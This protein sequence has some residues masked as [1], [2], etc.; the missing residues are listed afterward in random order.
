MS[1][2]LIDYYIKRYANKTIIER[3]W[4]LYK[5][6]AILELIHHDD[7]KTVEVVVEGEKDI[8]TVIISDYKNM[9]IEAVCDCPYNF[10][11]IC[12]HSVA[13]LYKLIAAIDKTKVISPVVQP[14][15]SK[16]KTTTPLWI[17]HFDR[18]SLSNLSKYYKQGY[19]YYSRRTIDRIQITDEGLSFIISDFYKQNYEYITRI[20][21]SNDQYYSYC[22][23]GEEVLVTCEHE[24]IVIETLINAGKRVLP[25]FENA[26]LEE[27]MNQVCKDN[28]LPDTYANSR[29]LQINLDKNFMPLV[30]FK[31]ELKGLV[32]QNTGF[33]SGNFY[34][35]FEKYVKLN[36]NKVRNIFDTEEYE[37][38]GVGFVFAFIPGEF[39]VG[40][41][42]T[43]IFGKL[44]AAGNKIISN[45][46]E[47]TVSDLFDINV[48]QNEREAIILSEQIAGVLKMI[49][50]EKEYDDN[51]YYL[52]K[53]LGY[54]KNLFLLLLGNPLIYRLKD[55]YNAIRKS[56]LH[57]VSIAPEP[58][59]L[60]AK[61]VSE[62]MFIALVPQYK[63]GETLIDLDDKSIV[64]HSALIWEFQGVLHLLRSV[65]VLDA[66]TFVISVGVMKT[67]N[68]KAGEFITNIVIP[69][70][71]RFKLDIDGLDNFE[72]DEIFLKPLKKQVFLS[73]HKNLIL[74]TPLVVYN[75]KKEA[76]AMTAGNFIEQV[77]GKIIIYKR[78]EDFEEEFL[79]FLRSLH[80]DF[81]YQ[82][83]ESAMGLPVA[84]MLKNN[85]F[86][87]AFDAMKEKNIEVHG[88]Q[89]LKSFKYSPYRATINTGISSGQDWFDVNLEVSFGDHKIPLLQLRKHILNKEKFIKLGDGTVGMM[90]G[91]W[92]DKLE[93]YFRIG[94][95]KKDKLQVS[96][97]RFSLVDELFDNIDDTDILQE[98]AEKK[99]RLEGFTE[100]SKVR[101]PSAIK[102]TLRDYQKEGL[103]WLNFLS[104]MS[105]GG[106]LAD[107]M[108]LGKTLQILAFLA[109][110]KNKNPKTSLV[111]VPTTLIFN[112][113]NEIKKFYPTLNVMFYY[114]LNRE[115][116]ENVFKKFN[117]VI[118]TYGLM[119]NDIE[120]LSK[121]KFNY[122]ILDESQS[123]KNPFSKR[124]KA[125][126]LLQ[127]KSKLTLT[128]TP[129]ENNTFDLF[130]Q[131]TFANPGLLGNQKSFKDYYSSPIDKEKDQGRANE[132]RKLISPFILRRTKEQVATELPPKT[133][134]VIYCQMDHQQR[135]LY[136]DY[137]NR[138]RDFILN[139]IDNEGL[140]KSKMS[141][142]EGLLKLRQIC[143]NPKLIDTDENLP[144]ESVK[145]EEIMRQINE[146]T[147]KH[148]IVIFSQ[149]VKML[150]L[151]EKELQNE[152]HDYEYFDGSSSQKKRKES[153]ERFQNDENCRI[154]LISLKAGGTGINLTA[155]DYVYIFD[156]WWN[157][158][159]ENQAIDRT[160]RIGQ[161]KKV[162]AYRMICKDTI[163][164]KIMQYQAQKKAL[165]ADIIRTDESFVKQL[166]PENIKD[167]F[168]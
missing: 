62:G 78:N 120:V 92:I 51:Y 21:K 26:K 49:G 13:A 72:T 135:I 118:T 136:D 23:C 43:P 2:A 93:K 164:E 129:I 156:P 37:K 50:G 3:G 40:D 159:V 117:L 74:F 84:E 8:Y 56:N 36:K 124:F 97:L 89:K 153:V 47:I 142:L 131:M 115:K 163:E 85:W 112:W 107:D 100:I 144:D 103:N 86:F 80:P 27:L 11:G 7:G 126:C 98:L 113:E 20:Y 46:E 60:V 70:S 162:F 139:K 12:K 59:D 146:K 138:Y 64:Q 22:S 33:K 10:N 106:I 161:D 5:N 35:A 95:I 94:E 110:L 151:I 52:N 66:I 116:D 75:H 76:D 39:G 130:A 69:F 143:N 53:N 48:N 157:P 15:P 61:L 134:D 114:G 121:L 90:P 102:A 73:E 101:K 67:I 30:L 96:K 79:V 55:E 109:S 41:S 31:G 81:Y 119:V 137:K 65:S 154:F 105:W 77:D 45:I 44:N 32:N 145:Q 99:R 14:K 148:K 141:I 17:E 54:L 128:G 91:E 152:G 63:I 6:G 42:V 123:I 108:G 38:T 68:A 58:V 104:E 57:A 34:N 155:A 168:G 25:Y 16:R 18:L 82:E 165:A 4:W 83:Q 133:E 1:V 132:L 147:G 19:Y 167:L 149:F 111:V 9:N 160:Y 158:A 24:A 125:A 87:D 122:I 127:G 140:G 166:T 88:L 28:E 150:K 29:F 71:E